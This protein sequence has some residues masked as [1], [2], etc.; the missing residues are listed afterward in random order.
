M[1]MNTFYV[2]FA[3]AIIAAAKRPEMKASFNNNLPNQN[4]DIMVNPRNPVNPDSNNWL[5]RA[6]TKP[7]SNAK[8][9]SKSCKS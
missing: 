7:M 9:S 3:A 2:L 1:E 8:K 5:Q 6:P 4:K